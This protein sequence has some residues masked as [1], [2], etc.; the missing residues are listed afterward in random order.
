MSKRTTKI[1]SLFKNLIFFLNIFTIH[2]RGHQKDNKFEYLYMLFDYLDIKCPFQFQNFYLRLGFLDD[3]ACT[4]RLKHIFD[5]N[6]HNENLE[7]T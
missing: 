6:C 5:S 7:E 3:K 1:K 4:D 2:S